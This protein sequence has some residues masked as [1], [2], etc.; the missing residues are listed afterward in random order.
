MAVNV[1]SALNA[2]KSVAQTAT[3]GG[4]DARPSGKS[5]ADMLGD[6]AS[7]AKNEGVKA[8]KLGASA[9]LGKADYAEVVTAVANA[10]VA[11]QTVVTVRDKMI[12]AYQDILKMPI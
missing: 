8:E 10:D 5:F 11:L 2:Y 3:G 1:T 6:M 12:A 7:A 4:M 9:L